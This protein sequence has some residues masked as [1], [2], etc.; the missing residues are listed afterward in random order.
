MKPRVLGLATAALA[1]ALLSGCTSYGYRGGSGDYYYG[2]GAVA[3]PGYYGY[4]APYGSV[5]YGR[6]GG[7]WSGGVRY[8]SPY[9]YGRPGYLYHPGY[10]YRPPV[11]VHP[12]PGH[13]HQPQ[14][15]PQESSGRPPWRDLG[16]TVRRVEHRERPQRV[17]SPPRMGAPRP[18]GVRAPVQQARPGGAPWRGGAGPGNA[19]PR[20]AGE[21][22]PVRSPTRQMAPR[23]PE[24]VMR[25]SDRDTS[26][27]VER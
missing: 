4:G 7:G 11:V 23:A 14:R 8:G 10:Y 12:R 27:N 6:Y 25:A 13:G 5:G 15:P 17:T 21:G 3:H 18:E 2:R 16:N 1:V 19:S 24:R 20:P 26:R 9:Y 22:R